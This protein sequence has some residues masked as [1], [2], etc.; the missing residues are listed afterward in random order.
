LGHFG[1]GDEFISEEEARELE[2]AIRDAGA[3]V[4]F[5]YYEGATHAFFN[6]LDRPERV[7][8]HDPAAAQSSWE[9]TV[10][11]LRGA[12]SGGS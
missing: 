3:E 9:R 5:H 11:F 12:L 1:T 10:G 6:D 2:S 7:G 4:T 8:V